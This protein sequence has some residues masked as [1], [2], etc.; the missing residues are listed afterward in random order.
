MD[1]PSFNRNQN[2]G[3]NNFLF[4]QISQKN[5]YNNIDPN[6]N[7][8]TK[9][10]NLKKKENDS[11]FI[12]FFKNSMNF[13]NKKREKPGDE[14]NVNILNKNDL[15]EIPS[16]SIMFLNDEIEKR[17]KRKIELEE[18]IQEVKTELNSLNFEI[19]KYEKIG[20]FL[21]YF[22]VEKESNNEGKI[23]MKNNMNNDS[24]ENNIFSLNKYSN[25]LN[26][27][28]VNTSLR[29][30]TLDKENK[31]S[32]KIESEKSQIFENISDKNKNMGNPFL[33]METINEVFVKK[34]N[35]ASNE[36][37]EEMDLYSFRILTDNLNYKIY[38]EKEFS[39][40]FIIENNGKLAW[41]QNETLLLID[42]S[43]SPFKT[44]KYYL[45]PLQPEE[46]CFVHLTFRILGKYKPGLY[47]NYLKF[48]VKGKNIGND[49]IINIELF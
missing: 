31:N 11:D 6:I 48:N 32:D 14:K 42:E 30:I 29:T 4:D 37:V 7:P 22:N 5:N 49:I 15:P 43:K 35:N 44:P 8:I 33:N 17:M 26:K 10:I 45:F 23:E 12:P 25:P 9:I 46:R 24:D 20:N 36:V 39:I 19:E 13:I 34:S 16:N 41:P 28:Y 18:S 2:I 40:E 3:E 47:K 27:L 1:S 21:Q 38:Q